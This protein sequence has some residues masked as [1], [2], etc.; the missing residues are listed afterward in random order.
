MI[1]TPVILIHMATAIAS[2][3]VGGAMFLMKKGT[4]QH[5]L[6]G[7]L[8]VVLMAVT[9]LVSFAIQ[10]RGHFSWI[11]LLSLVVLFMLVRAVLAV[12]RRNIRLHQRLVIGTYTGLLIAGMFALAPW[13]RLGHLV[14]H[15]AS[16]A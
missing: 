13:R 9:A 4:V 5:R 15:A 1:F 3:A 10:S 16:L 6:S 12:R 7:R 14:W 2:V 8:W 11:H